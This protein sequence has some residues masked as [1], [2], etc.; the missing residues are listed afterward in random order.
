MPTKDDIIRLRETTSDAVIFDY[1][2]KQDPK[3]SNAVS[4]VESQNPTMGALEKAQFPSAM[5]DIFYDIPTTT[6]DPLT[7]QMTSSA[8]ETETPRQEPTAEDDFLGETIRNIP[9]SALQVGK[10]IAGAVTSPVETVEAIGQTAVGGFANLIEM[11]TGNEDLAQKIG[12]DPKAEE[13]ASAVG[14]FYAERYGSLEQAAETLKTDPV[15]FLTDLAG[16]LSVAGGALRGAGAA[17]AGGLAATA[18]RVADPV[19]AAG[20]VATTPFKLLGKSVGALNN[21]NIKSSFNLTP[22]QVQKVTSMGRSPAQFLS[23]H[24]IVGKTADDIAKALG[25]VASRSYDDVNAALASIDELFAKSNVKD[26]DKIL[27]QLSEDFNKPGLGELRER[28]VNLVGK[29]ELSLT[30]LNEAKR[31]V[32]AAD[33]VFRASGEVKAGLS[34]K[35]TAKIRSDLKKFIEN[36]ASTRGVENIAE[37]N[38]TTQISRGLLKEIDKAADKIGGTERFLSLRDVI[39]GGTVGTATGNPAVGLLAALGA[40]I[41]ATPTMST[42]LNLALNSLSAS[43]FKAVQTAIKTGDVT[44]DSR[45]ILQ[46]LSQALQDAPQQPSQ[47]PPRLIP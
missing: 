44:A 45:R 19:A 33:D 37:L 30:E 31:L 46:S 4:N 24:N 8:L 29:D 6:S 9:S 7:V 16:G 10:D 26:L 28:V 2:K 38:K 1:F 20:K 13:V 23:D 41:A 47:L 39:Y 17:R 43:E 11:I 3:F 40:R 36:E 35:G 14:S 27:V 25:E 15:G 21:A 18:A 32:D 34:A 22:G 42:R 5:I 12:I